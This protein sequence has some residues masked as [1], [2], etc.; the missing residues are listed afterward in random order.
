[1]SSKVGK[2][3]QSHDHGPGQTEVPQWGWSLRTAGSASR[4]LQVFTQKMER[5]GRSWVRPVGSLGKGP[6]LASEAA[7]D[8]TVVW[9]AP[10]VTFL[11]IITLINAELQLPSEG[12]G[13]LVMCSVNSV[14]S[15]VKGHL[16][17]I[18]TETQNA[19]HTKLF[20]FWPYESQVRM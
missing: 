13:D 5:T 12:Y 17:V 4:W 6:R 18:C 9:R 2:V 16:H 14:S 7:V 20:S 19:K 8:S 11:A 15:V 10:W 1:M 3:Q